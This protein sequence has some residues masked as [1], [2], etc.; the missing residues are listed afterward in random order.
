MTADSSRLMRG[1]IVRSVRFRCRQMLE[2]SAPS[3][4]ST[5]RTPS[6]STR[7]SRAQARSGSVRC[8]TTLRSGCAL[9]W[10]QAGS[11]SDSTCAAP[12]PRTG[13]SAGK[14]SAAIQ[15]SFCLRPTH[16]SG[17]EASCCFAANLAACC[18]RRSSNRTTRWFA[19]S[20]SRSR[21][22][23]NRLSS[24]CSSTPVAVKRPSGSRDRGTSRAD[25]KAA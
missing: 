6:C 5:T 25:L 8:S 10:W 3:P 21:R 16:G 15:T 23:T 13:C 19:R 14:C 9:A 17:S 12:G 11:R 18:S 2:R 7:A 22:D 20:G 1:P 24:R 4:A